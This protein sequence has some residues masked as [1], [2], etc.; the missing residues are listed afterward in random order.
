[1]TP[2]PAPPPAKVIRLHAHQGRI[3][4]STAR[5]RVVAAGRRWGKTT[6]ARA[7]LLSSA[8]SPGLYWYVAPTYGMARDLMWRELVREIPRDWLARPPHET[9]LEIELRTGVIIGLHGA[10]RPDTLRGRGPKGVILDEMAD[11]DDLLW[12]EIIEPSLLDSRGWALII[13]TPKGYDHFYALWQ[14]GQHGPTKLADWESWQFLSRE[15]PHISAA[16]VERARATM[17]AHLFRQEYEASFESAS[18]AILGGLWRPSHRVSESDTVLVAQGLQ[19]GMVI[20]WHVLPDDS[21]VPPAHALIYGSVDYGYGDPAALH[22]HAATHDGH[23]RTFAE[24]YGVHMTDRD[25]A[26]RLREMVRPYVGRV[27]YVVYDP[28]MRGSR[29][30]VGLA[31]SI[32]EVYDDILSPLGV[33]LRPGAG[34]RAD[35]ESR[36]HRWM[37]ALAPSPDGLPWW[38]T[39]SA[40]PHLIRTVPRVPW[41]PDDPQVEDGSSENHCIAK[42]TPVVTEYGPSPIESVD[43]GCRVLTRDGLKRVVRRYA[44]GVRAVRSVAFADGSRL[45]G[46]AD[47]DVLTSRGWVRIDE[48]AN[49]DIVYDVAIWQT[50]QPSSPTRSKSGAASD[51][52]DVAGT[53]DSKA[54]SCTARYGKT[55]SAQYCQAFTSTIGMGTRPTTTSSIWLWLQRARIWRHTAPTQHRSSAKREAETPLSPARHVSG[56]RRII[57][58][59]ATTAASKFQWDGP[60]KRSIA[61]HNAT[62]EPRRSDAILDAILSEH[63]R[64]KAVEWWLQLAGKAVG[65][66]ATRSV[67]EVLPCGEMETFDLE[68]D[69][70]HEFFAGGVLVSNCYEGVGRLFSS[71]PF[72][73]DRPK[74]PQYVDL[75]PLSK[76]HAIARD[77]REV[78]GASTGPVGS[79]FRGL[80]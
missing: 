69:T 70:Q 34:G 26:E 38:S 74:E 16:D 35:R 67:T 75:D 76:S 61:R 63:S 19:P 25:Q 41:D 57:A 72:T 44:Q 71:R 42:G 33:R 9:R 66:A 48:L 52:T 3:F 45:V 77:R 27:E 29:N 73:P 54:C 37:Q 58:A 64:A 79:G 17:P 24:C 8:A 51:T 22:L 15:A 31:K 12:P 36:P 59:C 62:R 18:G 80:S 4:R 13:G 32:A 11:M 10:D 28:G 21:W 1:M 2:A 49:G 6:L 47:H 5:F 53:S 50:D 14:R 23:M 68:V 65:S 56:W 7:V 40:C 30:E 46:T 39:T 43:P 60:A 20:P 55:S 78:P